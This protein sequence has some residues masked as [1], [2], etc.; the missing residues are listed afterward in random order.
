M[1]PSNVVFTGN[2]SVRNGNGGLLLNGA[3]FVISDPDGTMV[4]AWIDHPAAD[5]ILGPCP[6][7]TTHE[8]LGS[9][10]TYYDLAVP[11]GRS[12]SRD[13]SAARTSVETRS[14]TARLRPSRTG[15]GRYQAQDTAAFAS[16]AKA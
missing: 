13:A 4:D 10:L 6:G 9:V 1:S 2:R 15:R 16:A 11:N 12:F 14:S 3:T 5:A 7:D 8:P